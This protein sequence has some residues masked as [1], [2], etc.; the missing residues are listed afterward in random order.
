M[1]DDEG[2]SGSSVDA[3]GK[4]VGHH[5]AWAAETAKRREELAALGVKQ[6]P[7]ALSGGPAAAAA[8]TPSPV[9]VGPAPGAGS[10]WNAAGTWEDRDVSGKAAG[11]LRSL[12]PGRSVQLSSA[13]ALHLRVVSVPKC[14]GSVTLVFSRGKAKP[15]F[16]VNAELSYE[17]HP[18]PSE[19]AGADAE[20]AAVPIGAGSL[21]F[22]ELSDSEGSDMFASWRV[23]VTSFNEAAAGGVKQDA[24][25]RLI[26]DR[27]EEFRLLFR[28]W[29]EA[30]K[31]L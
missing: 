21:H 19:A 31:K 18:T 20:G 2:V 15:G 8:A 26:R 1:S 3:S 10:A 16:E 30:V 6:G 9:P 4:K 13:P 27:V 23:D 5:Y 7:V 22:E 24:L 14:D 11:A 28:D 25:R 29:V 17:V 12:A